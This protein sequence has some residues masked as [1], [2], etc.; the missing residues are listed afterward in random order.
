MIAK[1]YAKL[2]LFLDITGKMES[3]YH[4]LKT[5]MHSISLC[6]VLEFKLTQSNGIRMSTNLSGLSCAEDNLVIKGVRAAL[7]QAGITSGVNLEIRLEKSIPTGAGMGGGSADCAAAI[8]VT[9]KLLGL[10]LTQEQKLS[11]AAECGADVPFC[12]VGSAAVCE[13][14][15]DIM[16]PIG[17]LKNDICF[18]VVKPNAAI[19]TPSAYKSFDTRGIFG[20][21]DFDGFM[22]A[23]ST[24]AAPD[25]AK[26]LGGALY[27]AFSECCEVEA[28]SDA[29][30]SLKA[31]GAY[32]AEMTGSG[33][34]VFGVFDDIKTAERAA[35]SAGC[36]FYGAYLPKNCGVEIIL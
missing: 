35:V 21:G 14:V 2:N 25:G 10:G 9:D 6:D 29:I 22:K 31:N 11:A 36:G 15:G 33:A 32:G 23:Y 12:L 5:V 24:N 27:N 26:R 34:A 8:A 16:T 13:G 19:S 17:P 30:K 3:G 28:V 1:A 4:S 18:A 7:K 20:A